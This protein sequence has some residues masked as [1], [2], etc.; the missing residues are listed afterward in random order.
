MII[1][2]KVSFITTSSNV[3]NLMSENNTTRKFSSLE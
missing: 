3:D 1:L 2:L